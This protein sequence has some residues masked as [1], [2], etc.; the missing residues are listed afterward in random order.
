MLFS[1]RPGPEKLLCPVLQ[2]GP[3]GDVGVVTWPPFRKA[4]MHL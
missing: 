3:S 2:P 4:A 1:E